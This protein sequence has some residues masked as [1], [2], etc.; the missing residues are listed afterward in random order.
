[1][2]AKF[3]Q[4]FKVQAVE[5]V[6]LRP[7]GV[8]VNEVADGLG[9]GHSTL[10]KWL[11]ASRNH[12][13]ESPSA[14]EINMKSQERRPED[15]NAEERLDM[16]ISCSSMEE[17]ALNQYC[18]EKGI[19]PHHVKQWKQ[20]FTSGVMSKSHASS[21]SEL[22]TLSSENKSLKKELNRKEKALAETAA[23]LVLQKKVNEY[24]GDEDNS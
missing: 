21:V 4:S 7:N 12:K 11:L 5:K 2:K 6:L 15:W 1:M 10:G 17:E 9:V 19:Y 8:T 22:R 23:L 13:F 3:T 14:G 16:I 18:R 20:D 24:W